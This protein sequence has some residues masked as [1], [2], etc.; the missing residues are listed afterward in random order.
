MYVPGIGMYLVYVPVRTCSMYVPGVCA[1][2]VPV[3][4]TYLVFVFL[5]G[6]VDCVL[7]RNM[8]RLDVFLE[9]TADTK[10]RET[11]SADMWSERP[12]AA[13]TV[14]VLA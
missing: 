7:W 1:S 11:V 10:L 14:H 6:P 5:R 4:C 13:V 2:V 12:T 9:F 8:L 3:V